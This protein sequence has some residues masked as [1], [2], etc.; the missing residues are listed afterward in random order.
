M[1]HLLSR[2]ISLLLA[3]AAAALMLNAC[4]DGKNGADGTNGTNAVKTTGTLDASTFTNDD[5]N[6]VIPTGKILSASIPGKNPVVKIQVVD[7]VSGGGIT[8]LKTFGLH[9]ARLVPEANGSSSYWVNYIDKGI[10]LPAPL[11]FATTGTG[12]SMKAVTG[13]ITK[14]SADPGTTLVTSSSVGIDLTAHPVGSVLIPGYT[15][16]DNGDGTYTITFGSDITSNANAPY[17]A[18]A[19][20]R[21]G[22]TVA[23]IATPGVTATGPLTAAG[24][25]NTSFL[26]QNRLAMAYDFIPATGAMLTDSNGKQAFARDIVT[27]EAC[28]QCHDKIADI[29]GHQA[30]RPNTQLCVM[31]HTSTNT[32]GEGEFVTFIHRIHMGEELPAMPQTE[33]VANPTK[34]LPHGALVTYKEQTYPQDI[35]NCNQ[36]HKGVDG[37]NWQAKPTRKNCGSCH[38]DINFAAGTG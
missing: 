36:C 23:S 30:A 38:N 11:A 16:V 13:A 19:I 9:I 5:L 12:S 35:R 20:H 2:R 25:V 7:K 29:G 27:T 14:P 37:A 22:V 17:D 26:A 33:A 24:V 18:T 6:N 32:S 3:T 4:S 34:P 31:C 21:I 15:V 28:N 8:G 10:S 1:Q